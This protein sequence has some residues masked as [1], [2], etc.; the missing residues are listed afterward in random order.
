MRQLIEQ[1]YNITRICAPSCDSLIGTWALSSAINC[2]EGSAHNHSATS[3]GSVISK[4][5]PKNASNDW[6]SRSVLLSTINGNALTNT[7]TITTNPVT[8]HSQR[9]KEKYCEA[10]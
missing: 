5:V 7:D 1:K 8:L 2:E 9:P 4:S 6:T 10:V 3:K